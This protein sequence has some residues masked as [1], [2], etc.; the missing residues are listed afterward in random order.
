[1]NSARTMPSNLK[2]FLASTTSINQRLLWSVQAD[3]NSPPAAALITAGGRL[4]LAI[5]ERMVRDLGGT[6][7]L[8]DT[9][10]MFFIASEKGGFYPCPGGQYRLD[11]GTPAVK[12]ITWRQVD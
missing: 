1:M 7:L 4:M 6:Y 9:D 11:D 10:S 3:G 8:T 12:A 5:L 2:F